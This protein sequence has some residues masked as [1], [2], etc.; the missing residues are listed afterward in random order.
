MP[1]FDIVSEVN[2]QEV[3]NSVMQVEKEIS[4]RYDFRES[5]SKIELFEKELEIKII[6]DDNVKLSAIQ[7]ILR[8]K[9]AKRGVGLRSLEWGEAETSSGEGLRQIIKLKQ[10]LGQEDAKK[11]TK[12]VKDLPY[13][14]SAQIQGEQIR[15]TGK[16]K[17]EL[18]SV[19]AEIR[20]RL[21]EIELQFTNFRD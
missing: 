9:L 2:L 18:Q 8:Q 7:E 20:S 11:V 1:S 19:I 13:K 17:D 3:K 5:A 10:G 16:K 14:V 12:L 6:A 4:T 15:I 21:K